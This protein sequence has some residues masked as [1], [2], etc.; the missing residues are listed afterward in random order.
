MLSPQYLMTNPPPVLLDKDDDDVGMSMDD[1]TD[2]SYSDDSDYSDDSSD[3]FYDSDD[4]DDAEN[5][6]DENAEIL[7]LATAN[8]T[9]NKVIHGAGGAFQRCNS[10]PAIKAMLLA[11]PVTDKPEFSTRNEIVRCDSAPLMSMPASLLAR[12]AK[13]ECILGGPAHNKAALFSKAKVELNMEEQQTPQDLLKQIIQQKDI[14]PK[15]SLALDVHY[16]FLKMTSKNVQAYDMAKAVA[17]RNCNIPALRAMHLKGEILQCCNRFGES[18]V[19]TACRRGSAVCIQFLT[20]EAGVSLRV[21]DDYGRTPLHDACWTNIPNFELIK[22]VLKSCPDLL[23][24]ADKRGYFPL[25][26][27]RKDHHGDWCKFL[28]ENHELLSPTELFWK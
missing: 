4:D 17:I 25:Q 2:D 6:N 28:E 13:A 26:Y 7:Q 21:R 15:F 3:G 5:G 12:M 22:L 11:G 1:D 16:F 24:V 27:V 19:H 9:V 20:Q 14:S 23:F 10:S 18:I 8:K